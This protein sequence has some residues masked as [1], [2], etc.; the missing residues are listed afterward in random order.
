MTV[1]GNAMTTEGRV[2]LYSLSG[3][4]TVP[5]CLQ[6]LANLKL[7]VGT[8]GRLPLH[9]VQFFLET[10]ERFLPDLAIIAMDTCNFP[11]LI[12]KVVLYRVGKLN[13]TRK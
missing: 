1:G 4:L 7:N 13:V 5:T 9:T 10:T 3:D 11:I 8:S 12:K 6:N 2:N